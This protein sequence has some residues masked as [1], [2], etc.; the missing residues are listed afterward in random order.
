MSDKGASSAHCMQKHE[1]LTGLPL[2]LELC[3][4]INIIKTVIRTNYLAITA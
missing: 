1:G 4:C 3:Q 2:L